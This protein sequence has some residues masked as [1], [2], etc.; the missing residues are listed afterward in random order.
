MSFFSFLNLLL[1]FLSFLFLVNFLCSFFSLW[2]DKQKQTTLRAIWSYSFAAWIWHQVW[3]R[4]N[5]CSCIFCKTVRAGEEMPNSKTPPLSHEHLSFINLTLKTTFV[6]FVLLFSAPQLG[7]HIWNIA[8]GKSTNLIQEDKATLFLVSYN[9][10]VHKVA[11]Q[12]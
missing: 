9:R 7:E 12:R 3:F 6:F 8:P 2:Q 1:F 5:V 4:S 10:L 11:L